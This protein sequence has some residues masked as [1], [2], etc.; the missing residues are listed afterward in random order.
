[1]EIASYDSDLFVELCGKLPVVNREI[2]LQIYCRSHPRNVFVEGTVQWFK[3]K[4]ELDAS[5]DG[6][7]LCAGVVFS[8]SDL[9]RDD[10][11][12]DLLECI[13]TGMIECSACGTL[14]SENAA[15]CHK[16]ASKLVRRRSLLREAI[17]SA[18]V[19]GPEPAA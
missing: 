11:I 14:V 7:N 15:L 18:L 10:G 16:C 1:M 5:C 3:Q 4:R 12:A 19:P 2:E 17:F 13:G 8:G 9:Q 6:M